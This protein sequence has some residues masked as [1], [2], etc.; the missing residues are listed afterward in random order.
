MEQFVFEDRDIL[1]LIQV[2]VYDLKVTFGTSMESTLDHHSI[3]SSLD[4]MHDAI[5]TVDLTN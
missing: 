2:S 1:V 4:L 5:I 3:T